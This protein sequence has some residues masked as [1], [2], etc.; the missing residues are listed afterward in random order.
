[1]PPEIFAAFEDGRKLGRFWTNALLWAMANAPRIEPARELPLDGGNEAFVSAVSWW[2]IAIKTRF[3]KLGADLPELRAAA[4]ESGV[5]DP[6]LLG[7]HAA[8]LATLPRPHNDP[9]GHLLVAQALAE[10]MRLITGDGI[11][12]QCAPLVAHI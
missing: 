12:S 2:K 11:L 7:W 1:L 4:R 9:F 8:V 5:M 6:P 3:G 10:P